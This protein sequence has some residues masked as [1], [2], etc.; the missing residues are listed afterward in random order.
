MKG[1]V[2]SHGSQTEAKFF[3]VAACW[4]VGRGQYDRAETLLECGAY[5]CDLSGTLSLSRVYDRGTVGPERKAIYSLTSDVCVV[6]VTNRV[7]F[8]LLETEN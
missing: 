2:F 6:G 5:L 3:H 7:W 4:L 8:R 1:E